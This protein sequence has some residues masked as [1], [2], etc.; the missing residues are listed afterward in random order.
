MLY[1]LEEFSQLKRFLSKTFSLN[2]INGENPFLITNKGELYRHYTENMISYDMMDYNCHDVNMF[3]ED[4]QRTY[5]ENF[6]R[7]KLPTT[8]TLGTSNRICSHIGKKDIDQEFEQYA[9]AVFREIDIDVLVEKEIQCWKM[10][11]IIF[12]SENRVSSS[13]AALCINRTLSKEFRTSMIKYQNKKKTKTAF[14][15]FREALSLK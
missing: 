4:F 15:E 12:D 14:R 8:R 11:K 10:A 9:Y 6:S 1:A 7:S 3:Y 2:E 5:E 13:L